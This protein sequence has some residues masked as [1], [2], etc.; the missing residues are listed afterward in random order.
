M[1]QRLHLLALVFGLAM[2][3]GAGAQEAP[4][5]MDAGVSAVTGF[6]GTVQ[7][8]KHDRL[9]TPLDE[10]FLDGNGAVLKVLDMTAPGHVWDGRFDAA[11]PER[12][13]VSARETGQVFGLALDDGRPEEAGRVHP[14][15]YATATSAF[16]LNI[17][18]PDAD[19]D[20]LPERVKTGQ[21][22]A[23]WMDFQ[24]GRAEGA[25]P[26]SI[27]KVDG[28]TRTVILFANVMLDGRANSGAG[29][30][31]IA[32]DAASGQL[33]VSDRETGM[34]HRFG[35]TGNDLGHFDHGVDGRR[36]AGLSEVAFDP[37][38]AL[39]VTASGFDTEDPET[40][41]YAAPERRIWGLAVHD[42]RLF[43]AVA[44]GESSG[45]PQIWS[46]GIDSRTGAF[47]DDPRWELDVWRDGPAL[48]V[49]DI[50]FSAEGAMIL[51]QRGEQTAA[52]DYSTFIKPRKAR[53]YRHWL[54][55]PDDPATPSRW[56]AEPEEYAAGFQ[57][58]HRN[59]N[60]GVALGYGFDARGRIN[61]AACGA[62]VWMSGEALR[63]NQSMRP[64]LEAAGEMIVHGVQVSPFR[65]VRDFN[66]PPWAGYYADF[67][68]RFRDPQVT[69]HLGDVEV[70][71]PGCEGQAVA[72]NYPYEPWWTTSW[73]SNWADTDGYGPGCTGPECGT[74]PCWVTGTCPP[75]P[76]AC[77]EIETKLTCDPKTGLWTLATS[78]S[79]QGGFAPDSLKVTTDAPGVSI[80]GGPVLPLNPA[81]ITLSGASPS[82]PVTLYM[83]AFVKAEMESG[84]PADC[85]R[86]TAAV[87]MPGEACGKK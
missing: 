4:P 22:G 79:G 83:C 15:I 51:A 56:I 70:Y 18:I 36:A 31:N 24:W 55:N 6:S 8:R 16:G 69:G 61:R 3:A 21:P 43:Y 52:Y 20:G 23:V 53:V 13:M 33:F 25:G 47:L 77:A 85:C 38:S 60:G 54:E 48:E 86:V 17:V 67:D 74:P 27:W 39:D 76:S 57:P 84:K 65:P 34:I 35:L 14:N 66:T 59:S 87:A 10:T 37:A 28:K 46:I 68:G 72:S 75:P 81:K 1:R 49:S 45:G 71:M 9:S 73:T 64:S 42:G 12:L 7:A 19:S 62:S 78:V 80:A 44:K 2:T 11:V 30:G 50:A 63:I 26:G 32:F 41:N 58:D 82:Q 5:L 29:L 40:W